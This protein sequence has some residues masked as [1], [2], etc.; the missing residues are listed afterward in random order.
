MKKTLFTV[1]TCLAFAA[2]LSP[3]AA[4]EM[5]DCKYKAKLFGD[6]ATIEVQGG[7]PVSYNW[8]SYTASNVTRDGKTIFID[9]AKITGLR[10]GTSGGKPAV[11]GT[12]N[13][14]G[15]SAPV[16]FVCRK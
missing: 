13:Y 6:T 1:S 8:G 3:A 7:N 4:S 9:A 11:G 12:W 2:F 15:N 5:A 14:Q 16:T 10:V